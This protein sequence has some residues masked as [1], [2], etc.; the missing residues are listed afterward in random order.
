MIAWLS[1]FV[2]PDPSV[3]ALL[4]LCPW[5]ALVFVILIGQSIASFF[6]SM[7]IRVGE[8]VT[9]IITVTLVL[10]FFCMP[11]A[12]FFNSLSGAYDGDPAKHTETTEMVL[13]PQG[14]ESTSR[15]YVYPEFDRDTLFYRLRVQGKNGMQEMLLSEEDTY[16][17]QTN[18][19]LAQLTTQYV[20][21]PNRGLLSSLTDRKYNIR[22]YVAVPTGTI[23]SIPLDDTQ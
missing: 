2:E 5:I 6:S 23:A 13:W 14:E 1:S 16:L 18:A 4:I 19:S 22:Y 7:A 20:T 11:F 8:I 21:Y 10:I 9:D 3:T 12:T 15:F 17:T